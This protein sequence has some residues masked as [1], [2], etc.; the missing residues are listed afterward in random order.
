MKYGNA[1]VS[2]LLDVGVPDVCDEFELGRPEWV[3]FWEDEVALEEAALEERV[4]RTDDQ[5]LQET[6]NCLSPGIREVN[7][8]VSSPPT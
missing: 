2:V 4:R 3:L 5:H 6:K 1:D 7:A 8:I